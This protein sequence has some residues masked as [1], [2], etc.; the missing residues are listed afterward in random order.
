M[1]PAYAGRRAA[2]QDDEDVEGRTLLG[3]DREHL[4]QSR[5]VPQ[6]EEC[7]VGAVCSRSGEQRKSG[8]WRR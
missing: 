3:V 5:A 8:A 1:R 6:A 2:A 7:A 4:A